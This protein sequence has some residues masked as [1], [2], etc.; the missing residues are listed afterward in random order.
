MLFREMLT[1]P[2]LVFGMVVDCVDP[3]R[4]SGRSVGVNVGMIYHLERENE[5]VLEA[6]TKTLNVTVPAA[7]VRE[8]GWD[9]QPQAIRSVSPPRL[10]TLLQSC[11]SA[12]D[13]NRTD[14]LQDLQRRARVHDDIV[15][16]MEAVVEAWDTSE[17]MNDDVGS[18]RY[19][20]IK[21]AESIMN[22]LTAN[23]ETLN[24]AA[25]A[26]ELDVSERAVYSAFNSW[27]S[28]GPYEF[29]LISRLHLFRDA[30]ISGH[31]FRGK[32][33][34][35]AH[36]AGFDHLARLSQLYRRHFGETPRDTMKRC[37]D[38][39]ETKRQERL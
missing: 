2:D 30:L 36:V 35:A 25:L 26:D 4:F 39:E 17:E 14:A 23:G 5:F 12:V 9:V 7:I 11:Q 37:S 38:N 21:Q 1:T 22:R 27:L 19:L 20:L 24:I 18:R 32:I 3:P 13:E 31:S 29:H 10:S 33:T 6:G 16:A 15:N 8:R 28:M 34:R